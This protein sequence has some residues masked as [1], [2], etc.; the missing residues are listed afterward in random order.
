[1]NLYDFW[2]IATRQIKV[3]GFGFSVDDTSA[4]L[5]LLVPPHFL[6]LQDERAILSRWRRLVE[7]YKVTGKPAHDARLVAAMLRHGLTH[8]LTFNTTDFSRY[9][10][11]EAVDPEQLATGAYA[12]PS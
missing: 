8:L 2:K 4:K 12:F 3:N 1:Q 11:I 5:S 9:T 6:L 7:T 10:E